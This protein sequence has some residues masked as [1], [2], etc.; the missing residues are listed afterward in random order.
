V[1]R[2]ARGTSTASSVTM[3][4]TLSVA[5]AV[6]TLHILPALRWSHSLKE[7]GTVATA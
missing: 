7:N 6:R 2:I 1:M 5:M 4:A 3:A